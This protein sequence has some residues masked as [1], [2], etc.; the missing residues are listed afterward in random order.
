MET[1]PTWLALIL[2]AGGI[3]GAGAM[4]I[5]WITMT[6]RSSWVNGN[7]NGNGR[8]KCPVDTNFL[9]SQLTGCEASREQAA[10]RDQQML[11]LL[12]QILEE[13]R[14]Q[15]SDWRKVQNDITILLDRQSRDR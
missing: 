7:G 1:L 6:I 13:L 15:R 2:V 4:I 11:S 5:R 8:Y 9:S 3:I 12:K 10:A 14:S